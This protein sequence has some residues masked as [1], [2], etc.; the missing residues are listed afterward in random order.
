MNISNLRNSLE[1]NN[2]FVVTN[3]ISN[4]FLRES[5]PL[6][7]DLKRHFTF[8]RNTSI[9]KLNCQRFLIDRLK[10]TTT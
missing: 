2:D 3:K 1:F 6:V 4:I 7:I 10:K 8:E 5:D 9:M